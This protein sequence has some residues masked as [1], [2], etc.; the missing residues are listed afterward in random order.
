MKKICFVTVLSV[1]IPVLVLSQ[2]RW[3]PYIYNVSFRIK[4][5][6]ISINGKFTGFKGNLV[7]DTVIYPPVPWLLL[8]KQQPS[9]QV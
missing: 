4:N 1:L 6:G 5:A 8:L 7:F 9:K 3:E 2:I